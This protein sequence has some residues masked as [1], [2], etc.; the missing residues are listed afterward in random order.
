MVN[1]LKLNTEDSEHISVNFNH[2]DDVV[3]IHTYSIS[4]SRQLKK[5]QSDNIVL[6]CFVESEF[7][8]R[9]CV[10]R[11]RNYKFYLKFDFLAV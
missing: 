10:E 1:S 7:V 6:R 4:I 9:C 8:L 3:R 2:F 11:T 5:I